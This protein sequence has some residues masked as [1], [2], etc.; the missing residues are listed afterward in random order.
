[1]GNMVSITPATFTFPWSFFQSPILNRSGSPCSCQLYFLNRPAV[2]LK[3]R[4][5]VP[6]SYQLWLQTKSDI[7]YKFEFIS[8]ENVCPHV[9]Q[10]PARAVR[11]DIE[12]IFPKCFT[13][14][15]KRREKS[16]RKRCSHVLQYFQA[17]LKNPEKNV[18]PNV[19]Q[20]LASVAGGYIKTSFPNCFTIPCKR[21]ERTHRKIRC[22]YRFVWESHPPYEFLGWWE[23]G[24]K[25]R[26]K[27]K[28]I[29]ICLR[30]LCGCSIK[31]LSFNNDQCSHKE[32]TKHSYI[33]EICLPAFA[34]YSTWI[35]T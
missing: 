20:Y 9:L 22:C 16:H 25:Y 30:K 4:L 8:A 3:A 2:A 6:K 29:H 34:R 24:W 11:K 31:Y 10:Y 5:Q 35:H 21:R 13:V 26:E 23:Q 1:M 12:T 33:P 14:P 19:L 27:W 7:Y 18:F 15:C 28:R 32:P 17:T